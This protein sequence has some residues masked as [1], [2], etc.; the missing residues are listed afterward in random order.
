M[1]NH[2]G[3]SYPGG[4]VHTYWPDIWGYLLISYRIR[5][6]IDIGCGYGHNL[7]WFKDMGCEVLGVEGDEEALAGMVDGVTVVKHDYTEGLYIPDRKFDLC[8]ATE[9]VE[10]V[11]HKYEQNWI[12]TTLVAEYLLICHA[13]PG[14][15]GH[16]HVNEQTSDYWEGRLSKAGWEYFPRIS[17]AFRDTCERVPAPWGRPTAMFFGRP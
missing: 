14:Q 15:G 9:F 8:L 1:S 11:D 2:L 17:Q 6:V 5:S 4:D 13:V 12:D 7:K 10:H 16:H 3:G